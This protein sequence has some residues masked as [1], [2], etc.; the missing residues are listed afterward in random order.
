MDMAVYALLISTNIHLE[1]SGS[2]WESFLHTFMWKSRIIIFVANINMAYMLYWDI[3]I[4]KAS[5][6]L[7]L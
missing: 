1:I 2:K 6:S 3:N 7:T 5:L 4:D